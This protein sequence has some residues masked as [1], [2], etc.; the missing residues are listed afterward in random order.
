MIELF[1]TAMLTIFSTSTMHR[2]NCNESYVTELF[3]AF[4]SADILEIFKGLNDFVKLL[5]K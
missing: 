5:V 2:I 3:D 1:I 4:T